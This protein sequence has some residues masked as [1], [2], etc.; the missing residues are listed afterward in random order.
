MIMMPYAELAH[1]CSSQNMQTSD[2]PQVL[3]SQGRYLMTKS[4][5]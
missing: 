4:V 2:T 3:A 5:P 1:H